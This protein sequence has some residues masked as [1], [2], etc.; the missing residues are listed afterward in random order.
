[1]KT[2]TG[3][4]K[5]YTGRMILGFLVKVLGTFMDLG[6]P[7]VLAYIIDE[8]I[9]Q[10]SYK[11][12]ALWGVVMLLLAVGARIFNVKA[13][14]M[15]A[16]VGHDSILSIRHDLFVRIQTLSGRQLDQLGIASL[17]SRMTTDTYNIHSTI[18][19]LQRI[20]VRAPI[21]LVGGII[22]TFT[23]E[24]VLTV[25][26]LCCLPI[27]G[28]GIFL[29]SRMGLPMYKV[30]QQ[31]IDAMVRVVRENITGVRVIKALSKNDY[32]RRRFA[33]VNQAVCSQDFKASRTMGAMNPMMNMVLN[34]ALTVMIVVGAYRVNDGYTDVGTIMA[35]LSYFTMIL[36]A[37]MSINRIF[38]DLSKSSASAAR[39]REVL[40]TPY[41][42]PVRNIPVQDSEYHIE[43]KDVT[44]SYH[45]HGEDEDV[46]DCLSHISFA[47][48]QGES[49]GIIGSTGSGK[50]TVINLLM[51]F[52]D[53][54]SGEV[55][56]H[57]RNVQNFELAELRK[58]FGVVFQNDILFADTVY[59]NINF[60]RGLSREAVRDAAQY[61]QAL[62]F[63]ESLSTGFDYEVAAKGANFSGGQKQRML[64]ARS[65]AAHP[66]ILILDDSSSALDYKTDAE[67]RKALREHFDG[68]TNIIIA[69]RISSIYQC[70]H[71]M[72]LEDGQ[73]VGYGKHEDLMENCEIYR[74]IHESQMRAE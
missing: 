23:M 70:D 5:P 27:I 45:P 34:S 53:T 2:I 14:Q 56:I 4:L 71:I 22:I 67:L 16:K 50:T 31:K 13:N 12:I 32:E 62:P 20:G 3:Y 17:I 46:P 7:W 68:T 65:L 60:G 61:A 66:E 58:D 63:I 9:P 33:E 41:D 42:Q 18:G 40:N 57:G 52:Y 55:L 10:E 24:P 49:L 69:Q 11:L 26:L 72:V 1:M 64:I 29:I 73:C 48:K 43:F 15:A 44:F 19:R 35:F 38:I 30:L 59:E 54:D 51:R 6:L 8:V 25:I 36:N 21:I 28:V 74:E 47:L 39:I 37:V